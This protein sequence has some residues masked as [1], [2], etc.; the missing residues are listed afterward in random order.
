MKLYFEARSINVIDSEGNYRTF[1]TQKDKEAL[2]D[3]VKLKS[4]T[5]KILAYREEDKDKLM[6]NLH[7]AEE[8]NSAIPIFEVEFHGES[9]D[10]EKS[11]EFPSMVSVPAK[12]CRVVSASIAYEGY[13]NIT[14]N[15]GGIDWP[16]EVQKKEA[17]VVQ[18][19]SPKDPAPSQALVA[20]QGKESTLTKWTSTFLSFVD[21]TKQ[22]VAK[23]YQSFRKGSQTAT[24]RAILIVSAVPTN[25]AQSNKPSG[26]SA[27]MD[28]LSEKLGESPSRLTTSANS[29]QA[30]VLNFSRKSETPTASIESVKEDQALESN[31][32]AVLTEDGSGKSEQIKAPKTKPSV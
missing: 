28:Q 16:L 5:S 11:S 2:L 12:F 22:W 25:G 8:V 14:T 19:A 31:G 6:A 15:F 26:S 24:Q 18:V 4:P 10:M 20:M 21:G 9:K 13:P 27:L 3:T 30:V 32:Q 23:T 17:S 1:E 7:V 29:S